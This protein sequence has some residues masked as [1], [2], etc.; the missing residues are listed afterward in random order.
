[1]KIKEKY[2]EKGL[3]I[4]WKNFASLRVNFGIRAINVKHEDL[5]EYVK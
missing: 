2:L 5:S 4:N 1:M 3:T